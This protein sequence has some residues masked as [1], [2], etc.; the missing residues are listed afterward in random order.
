M[1]DLSV[2]PWPFRA[3]LSPEA[4]ASRGI[5]FNLLSIVQRSEKVWG[6]P[7]PTQGTRMIS[8]G[9]RSCTGTASCSSLDDQ[10]TGK[11]N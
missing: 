4:K 9:R 8:N 5:I 6:S 7:D 3:L 1:K 10:G 2:A 11:R